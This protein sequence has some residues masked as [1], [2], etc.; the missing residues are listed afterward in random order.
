M[1]IARPFAAGALVCLVACGGGS[2]SSPPAPQ[3]DFTIAVSPTSL[4]AVEGGTSAVATVSITAVNGFK[5]GAAVSISGLP[6]GATANPAFPLAINAGSSQQFTITTTDATPTGTATLTAHATSG[7]LAH[8]AS[9][10]LI[11]GPVVKT[12]QEGTVLYLQSHANGHTARIGLDTAWGGAII[13]VSL[14]G[15]N[16]VNHDDPG[17]EVQPALYDGAA[18]YPAWGPGSVYGWDPVLAGDAYGHGSS[19]LQQTISSNS[20]Y[21]STA[22]LQWW[23]DNFGGGAST[24]VAADMTF[25]Q[26]VALA[27]GAPLAFK[28]HYRLVHSGSDTHYNT[29]Q[30]FPAVYVNSAYTTFAYY[31]G[32][33]PWTNGAI[34][35]TPTVAIATPPY[36][37]PYYVPEQW[38]ALVDSGNRGLT[39]YVP[40][41]IPLENAWSF[42][43][44]ATVYMSPG[45]DFTI[46]AGAVIEGDIYLVPGDV[47]AARAAIYEIHRTLSGTNL[48]APLANVDQPAPNAT[49]SGIAAVSGWAFGIDVALSGV[50]VYLDGVLVGHATL[51]DSRP[52]V[53]NAYPHVAPA[54][55]GWNFTFDTTKLTNGPHTIVVHATDAANAEA[56]LVPVAVTISN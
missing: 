6:P 54:N 32:T 8:D 40:G 14:D 23:P 43:G 33:S 47:N 29:G 1:W 28:V 44:A 53:V 26:T 42:T 19:V 52:D 50:T 49:L 34:T 30:E 41:M 31:G 13:E 39:V 11:T 22:P 51:G 16:F 15:T 27:S 36:P 24:P 20:L 2:G 5:G 46:A 9:L 55:S 12:S 48:C 21:T 3:P 38:G 25:E 35:T 37:A 56:I 4:T 7:S 45:V 10:T 18:Q 17:R